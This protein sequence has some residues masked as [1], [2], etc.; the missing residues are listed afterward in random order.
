MAHCRFVFRSGKNDATRVKNHN[1][2]TQGQ[3]SYLPITF[4][5]IQARVKITVP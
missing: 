3:G 5:L 2:G 1:R 4:E